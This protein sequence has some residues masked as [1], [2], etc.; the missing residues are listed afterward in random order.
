MVKCYKTRA[1]LISL[2]MC[3]HFDEYDAFL[4]QIITDPS[5]GNRGLNISK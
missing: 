3:V 2:G 5:T 1:Y 4:P